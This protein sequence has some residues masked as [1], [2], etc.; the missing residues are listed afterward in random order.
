MIAPYYD[1]DGI[2]IYHGDCREIL[3][4]LKADAVVTDPPYCSGGAMRGDRTANTKDKYQQTEVKRWSTLPDFTGDTRD[5][6]GYLAWCSL[7]LGDCWRVVPEGAPVALFTD[8]RQCPVTTDAIQAG[9]WV[10]RGIAVWDKGGGCRPHMGRF[11][12]QAEFIVWG[13]KGPMMDRGVGAL[14]GVFRYPPLYEGRDEKAHIAQKPVELMRR[15]IAICPPGNLVLDPFMGS[16]TTLVAA[17]AEGRRAIGIEIE[18][19]YCE[20]AVNRLRQGVLF[21]AE[22]EVTTA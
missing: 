9:G 17:K 6:R 18:E 1:Q 4:T 19:R 10:W 20:S 2:T 12:A 11:S 3:P 13:S 8:W 14:P 21:G 15:V 7:W 16:G 5:Q 22:R